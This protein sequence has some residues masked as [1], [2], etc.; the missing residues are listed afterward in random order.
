MAFHTQ[1]SISGFIASEPQQTDTESGD[2][3][4]YVRIGQPH[5]RRNDDG[6][7]SELEPTFHDMVAYRAT[8]ERALARFV[9]GDSFVA[10]GYVQKAQIE[11]NG[12]AIEVE[13]FV[14]KKLGHDVAR[15]NYEVD[16]G[17]RVAAPERDAVSHE[18]SA[19][20]STAAAASA[21][22]RAL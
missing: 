22:L 9:K 19:R 17:Q 8:A 20:N 21:G 14:A 10:E 16:R 11:R 2:T 7:F 1:Q 12:Q 5:F 3:R 4:F 18:P 15:T 13:E 6:S